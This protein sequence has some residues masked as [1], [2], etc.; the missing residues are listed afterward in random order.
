MDHAAILRTD[1]RRALVLMTEGRWLGAHD[2]DGRRRAWVQLSRRDGDDIPVGWDVFARLRAAGYL[3][4]G[5][6]LPRGGR[7]FHLTAAGRAILT[8]PGA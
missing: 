5:A 6:R 8:A 2:G 3:A 1:E 4:A 7:R